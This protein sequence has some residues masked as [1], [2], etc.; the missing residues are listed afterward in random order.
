M[1]WSKIL[2]Y[3]SIVAVFATTMIFVIRGQFSAIF[4]YNGD[5]FLWIF[6]SSAFNIAALICK[7]IS[8]QNEKS[9]V[10]AIF[11]N[12]GIVYA[13]FIDYFLFDSSLNWLEWIGLMVILATTFAL[14]A[15]LLWGK[16]DEDEEKNELKVQRKQTMIEA[17]LTTGH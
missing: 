1:H 16:S 10:V 13:G 17:T 12:V 6:I 14:T 11:R 5:Q 15:H 9:G 4:A 3:Y 7:I 8:S 2:F